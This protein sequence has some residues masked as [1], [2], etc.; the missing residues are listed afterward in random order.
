MNRCTLTCSATI[1]CGSWA[2]H[3]RAE[4]VAMWQGTHTIRKGIIT[5]RQSGDLQIHTIIQL[6]HIQEL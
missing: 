4:R 2:R 3:T 5:F 1:S 6:G